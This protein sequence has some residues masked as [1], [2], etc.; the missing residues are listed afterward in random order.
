[1]LDSVSIIEFESEVPVDRPIKADGGR[2]YPAP[3]ALRQIARELT[4]RY[5]ILLKVHCGTDPASRIVFEFQ[6]GVRIPAPEPNLQMDLSMVQFGYIGTGTSCFWAFL[7]ESGFNIPFWYLTNTFSRKE[8]LTRGMIIPQPPRRICTKAFGI[9]P[10]E[11]RKLLEEYLP[12]VAREITWSLPSSHTVTGEAEGD[13]AAMRLARLKIPLGAKVD[14]ETIT[15]QSSTGQVNASGFTE[16]DAEWKSKSSR[17]EHT[18]IKKKTMNR[19][20]IKIGDLDL[21][22]GKYTFEYYVPA[23]AKITYR[24]RDEASITYTVFTDQAFR[25]ACGYQAFTNTELIRHSQVHTQEAIQHITV[26]DFERFLCPRWSRICSKVRQQEIDPQKQ[27]E[28]LTL[29]IETN[30]GTFG[31]I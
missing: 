16:W 31:R 14:S 1:M 25:F 12:P 8:V 23:E 15:R 24:S 19:R 2:N 3:L 7:D 17:P 9:S 5:G 27:V 18:I 11:C 4:S 13:E 30:R 20:P 10:E 26:G 6:N 28:L 29:Y 22:P 21:I